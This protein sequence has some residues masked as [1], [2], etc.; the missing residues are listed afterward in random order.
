MIE[1]W[2]MMCNNGA[3]VMIRMEKETCRM[4]EDHTEVYCSECGARFNDEI[5]YMFEEEE[6]FK[7]CPCCARE[8]IWE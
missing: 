3:E 1:T 2:P 8:I 4:I 5:F 6:D 7:Y